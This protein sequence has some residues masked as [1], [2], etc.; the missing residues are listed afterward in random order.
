MG[1]GIQRADGGSDAG[2]IGS[3]L[4]LLLN[5]QFDRHTAAY[6]GYSHFFAGDFIDESG[7]GEDIDF[8]YA[9]ITYTF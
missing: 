3:K 8:F 9:A 2:F 4:D 6:L 1:S 5:W 7:P